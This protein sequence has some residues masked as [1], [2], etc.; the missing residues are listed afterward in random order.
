VARSG[1]IAMDADDGL[2]R[3]DH[4]PKS[5]KCRSCGAV[6][7]QR[8]ARPCGRCGVVLCHWCRSTYCRRCGWNEAPPRKVVCG[9]GGD[10]GV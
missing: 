7:P 4:L 8:L 10:G 5:A 2:P 9:G 3:Y 6:V 1:G